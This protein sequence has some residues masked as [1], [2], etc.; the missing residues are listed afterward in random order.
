MKA[1]LVAALA[2]SGCAGVV[3]PAAGPEDPVVSTPVSPD[4]PDSDA[5]MFLEVEP[6]DGLVDITPHIWDR[7]QPLEPR[8]IRVEFYGGVEECDG[9]ARVDVDETDSSVTITLHTGRVPTAEVCIEIAVLKA[10]T[11]E[12][13]S[14]LGDREIVDGAA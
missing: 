11:V 6:R 14:P 12:L 10:V 9:L 2:L 4:D 5:P 13:D 8:T 3:E 7:A 1:F